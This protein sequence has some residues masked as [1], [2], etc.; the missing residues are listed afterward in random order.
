VPSIDHFKID[1][2]ADMKMVGIGG[3]IRTIHKFIAGIFQKPPS[4]SHN[5]ISMTKKM[6]DISNDIFKRLSQEELLLIRLIDN[7]RSKTI[8]AGSCVIKILM[9][10]LDF[11]KL[12]VCP[13]GLRE[14]ILENYLYFSMDKKYRLRKKF[15]G[16]NYG[17]IYSIDYSNYL[18]RFSTHDA[19]PAPFAL[20]GSHGK[21]FSKKIISTKLDKIKYK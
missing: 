16:L 4:F 20:W 11:D 6:I 17:D 8:T 13:T 1:E 12:F 21:N 18:D 15:I 9:E 14:G 3:T 19:K 5:H 2:T 10:K 7:Q